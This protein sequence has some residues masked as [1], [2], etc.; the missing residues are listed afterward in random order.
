MAIVLFKKFNCIFVHIPKTGGTSIEHFF[1]NNSAK[2]ISS[3]RHFTAQV[4][5]EKFGDDVWG[6]SFKFSIIRNPWDRI[7]SWWCSTHNC[8]SKYLNNRDN[9]SPFTSMR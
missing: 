4:S 9:F 3:H 5:K 8:G 2:Y 7:Y 6:S 1:K